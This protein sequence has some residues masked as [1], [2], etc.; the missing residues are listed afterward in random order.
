MNAHASSPHADRCP[1][2]TTSLT[3]LM[4]DAAC[5]TDGVFHSPRHFY[6]DRVAFVAARVERLQ[7]RYDA[8]RSHKNLCALNG[9]VTALMLAENE[10]RRAN[11]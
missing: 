11:G 6:S 1:L 7:A 5:A 4:R 2:V 10:A 9:A 3:R 8:N